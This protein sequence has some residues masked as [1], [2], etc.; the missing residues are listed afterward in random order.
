MSCASFVFSHGITAPSASFTPGTSV[1]KISAS[2]GKRRRKPPPSGRHSRCNTRRPLP[3]PATPAPEFLPAATDCLDPAR[4]RRTNLAHKSQ[5]V[6]AKCFL[7]ARNDMPSP[8]QNPIAGI[9]GGQN[10]GHQL[11]VDHAGQHHQRD[12]ASLRVGDAQPVHELALSCRVVSACGSARC[13]RHA[14]RP[15]VSVLR[16]LHDRL[17]ALAQRGLVLQRRAADFDYDLHCSP[18]SSFH[19]Y[20]RFMFCTACP[21]AP[22]SRLSTHETSTNR[23]PSS[24]RQNPRSQ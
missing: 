6:P 1:R 7:R 17:R 14:P 12:V 18:S 3:A 2:H 4:F 13:H 5:I 24:A 15:P 9:P 23:R 8:P 16:Q 19:P 21:A 11:L 22:F 10:C 20:I